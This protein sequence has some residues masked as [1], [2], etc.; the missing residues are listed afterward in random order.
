MKQI[1]GGA[2][3]GYLDQKLEQEIVNDLISSSKFSPK[4]E[5]YTLQQIQKGTAAITDKLYDLLGDRIFAILTIISKR[6][7]NKSVALEFDFFD[8]NCQMFTDSILPYEDFGGLFGSNRSD[9]EK[10]PYLLSFVVRIESYHKASVLTAYDVPNGLTEEYLLSFRAGRHDDSDIVDTLQEYWSDWGAFGTPLYK[11]QDHFGWDCTEAYKKDAPTCNNCTLS[12][13]V[14]ANPFDAWSIIQLALQK[15]GHWYPP[16]DNNPVLTKKQWYENRFK[17]FVAQDALI[18]GALAMSRTREL[19]QAS[20]WFRTSN[21]PR[22]DRLKLGGIHRAQPYSHHFEPGNFSQS[23]IAPWAHFTYEHRVK[24]YEEMRLARQRATEVPPE[25]KEVEEIEF[26]GGI[27]VEFMRDLSVP[28]AVAAVSLD[29]IHLTNTAVL[30][31]A[32]PDPEAVAAAA[33]AA[34]DLVA[35]IEAL[36]DGI[37]QLGNMLGGLNG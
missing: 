20:D 13:H 25:K 23:Y 5:Q 11:H 4:S 26:G 33:A 6:L 19:R 32:V 18:R 15:D 16:T 12:R 31:A 9:S 27:W 24:L 37:A 36:G 30:T 7:F 10:P 3:S 34:A 2:F 1:V 22:Y 14:W 29:A 21:E 35:S 8:N 17:L 28:I